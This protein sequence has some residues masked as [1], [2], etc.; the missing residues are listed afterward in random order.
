MINLFYITNNISEAQIVDKLDIDWIF[1]DLETVGKKDRQ[2]GRN[3][4]MSDHSISDV[5]KIRRV[6]N[7]TKIL[8][9]CNPI[10]IH[11]K[12][13]IEEINKT[14][15]IDMVMLPFFKTVKEVKMFI[16]LLDTSKVE[17]TL[18]IETTSALDNL[19]DI[20]KLYPFKYVH[21]GLNDIH[22]ERNT[23]FMF[24][25]YIDGLLDK[26]VSILRSNNKKFGIGGIG[27][28]G[29]DL[30]PTPEC[31]INEHTRL[32][33][34]GVILSRSFKGNFSEESKELFETE[35]TQSVIK[36]RKQ[37]KY[38]KTLDENQLLENYDILKNDINKVVKNINEKK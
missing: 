33:S 29:S 31:V 3:T 10:G 17:P 7:N 14:S 8:L 37:E 36:F 21:I 15:G 11:S 4:V 23:S 20:L 1:I 34:S 13:E 5:Q 18:L 19:S 16:E 27:K 9:R 22:I 6:I 28:I 2:I 25:P 38:S 35:L 26:A 12:K 24:E 32:K 30:L